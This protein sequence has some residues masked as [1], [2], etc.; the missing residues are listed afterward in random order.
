MDLRYRAYPF[1]IELRINSL[2]SRIEF[3]SGLRDIHLYKI[4]THAQ[5]ERWLDD[6]AVWHA[7][8]VRNEDHEPEL[9]H[10]AI[11][12][13]LDLVIEHW[14]KEREEARAKYQAEHPEGVGGSMLEQLRNSA[15]LAVQS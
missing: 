11:C 6:L 10:R 15:K 3:K 12:R 8:C 14:D 7:R 5:H 4:L 9:P 1:R 2:W 13:V